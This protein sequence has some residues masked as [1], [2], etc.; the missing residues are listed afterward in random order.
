MAHWYSEVTAHTKQEALS[1]HLGKD[2]SI[3]PVSFLLKTCNCAD[4]GKV[5][6]IT[7]II[8]TL[9]ANIYKSDCYY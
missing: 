9:D 8:R 4:G 2:F 7:N 6:G 3:Y 1:T 5:Q